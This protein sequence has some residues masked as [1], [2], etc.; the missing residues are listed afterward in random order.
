MN[1]Y[2]LILFVL[3]CSLI[4]SQGLL[5]QGDPLDNVKVAVRKRDYPA[6]IN[7]LVAYLNAN[8]ASVGNPKVDEAKRI[9]LQITRTHSTALQRAG[10][11][12]EAA[13]A[14]LDTAAVTAMTDERP[15]LQQEAKTLLQDAYR[16]A[17]G[18]SAASALAIAD[19]FAVFFPD[20]PP[21]IAPAE[22]VKLELESL[23]VDK[24]AR[25]AHLLR[26]IRRL[27]QAGVTDE[28]LRAAG[29]VES[30][31]V[32][33]YAEELASRGWALQA[34]SFAQAELLMADPS[35]AINDR[36]AKV[37]EIGRAHV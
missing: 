27:K 6:A 22:R 23:A 35:S 9:L 21:L 8:A 25:A 31:L 34:A 28:Q 3:G 1:L 4:F 24:K 37:A 26:E 5:A 7:M 29:V 33:R 32:A 14:L 18:K 20:D 13:Q 10:K 19:A 11:P 12:V 36:L 17:S 30:E 15:G 16:V 2:K